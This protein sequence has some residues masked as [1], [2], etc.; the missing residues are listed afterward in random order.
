MFSVSQLPALNAALN[1]TSALL[2]IAGYLQI[3]ALRVRQHRACMLSAFAVSI[4][5]LIS[6]LTYHYHAGSMRFTGQGWVRPVYF[7]VLTSHTVLAAAVPVLAVL[8]LRLA[9]RREFVR[10]RRLAR[11]TFPIWLYVSVTGV[12]IYAFL[13]WLY[14]AR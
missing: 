10:H 7:A 3:R 12:A 8:T 9:W 1:A 14:P 6:Y 13:Y 11:W 5:F 2:L 4:L